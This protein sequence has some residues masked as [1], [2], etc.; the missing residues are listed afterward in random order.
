MCEGI[1]AHFRLPNGK[2]AHFFDKGSEFQ[3]TRSS[4]QAHSAWRFPQS[5]TRLLAAAY[6]ANRQHA[7]AFDCPWLFTWANQSKHAPHFSGSLAV[8]RV[9]DE[10]DV[11]PLPPPP[12]PITLAMALQET[13][14]VPRVLRTLAAPAATYPPLQV[15]HACRSAACGIRVG[16]EVSPY[17]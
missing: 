14:P 8:R 17:G 10:V 11:P 2:L 3:G 12:Q 9:S 13:L 1:Y 6:V 16:E 5:C 4:G 7:V 15:V